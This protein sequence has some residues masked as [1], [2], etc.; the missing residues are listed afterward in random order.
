MADALPLMLWDCGYPDGDLNWRTTPSED[1]CISKGN[2]NGNA[3]GG[4]DL[5][6]QLHSIHSR[7]QVYTALNDHFLTAASKFHLPPSSQPVIETSMSATP[8]KL[9]IPLGGGTYKRTGQEKYVP[10]LRRNRL[11]AVE[12]TNERWRLG[13]GFRRNERRNMVEG[14]NDYDHDGNE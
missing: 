1:N 4:T 9:L 5:Y 8:A 10:L 11:D 12:V 6:Q 2:A 14:A 3:S 7:S 13:K